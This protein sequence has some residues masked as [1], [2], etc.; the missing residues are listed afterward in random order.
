MRTR[1]IIHST[2]QRTL[3]ET[4]GKIA[5]LTLPVSVQL[6][7]TKKENGTVTHVRSLWFNQ[8][9]DEKLVNKLGHTDAP[10]NV[11]FKIITEE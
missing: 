7:P 1:I 11:A 8:L 2:D 4:T 6:E 10:S 5:N 3:D 9:L